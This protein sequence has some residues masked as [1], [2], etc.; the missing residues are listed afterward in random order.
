MLNNKRININ[1]RHFSYS[2]KISQIWYS[3]KTKSV[4]GK[5]RKIKMI[6]LVLFMNAQNVKVTKLNIA[7]KDVSNR[8]GLK[9]ISLSVLDKCL[10]LEIQFWWVMYK[11]LKHQLHLSKKHMMIVALPL[12]KRNWVNCSVTFRRKTYHLLIL[13]RLHWVK[14]LM[15]RYSLPYMSLQGSK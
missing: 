6:I 7:H 15:E 2:L 8:I 9:Y 14:D 12:N 10:K 5:K 4:H 1:L 13:K 11:E 3:V